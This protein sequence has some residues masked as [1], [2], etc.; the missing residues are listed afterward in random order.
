MQEEASCN[1]QPAPIRHP[2]P[3]SQGLRPCQLPLHRGAKPREGRGLGMQQKPSYESANGGF[4]GAFRLW[5][6]GPPAAFLSTFRRWKVDA[7]LRARRR[8]TAPTPHSRRASEHTDCKFS[9]SVACGDSSLVRGRQDGGRA[10]HQ[11]S[12]PVCLTKRRIWL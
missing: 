7:V 1:R 12:R 8:G 11:K 5:Y 9:P 2:Q 4:R 6:K 10:A 3:L